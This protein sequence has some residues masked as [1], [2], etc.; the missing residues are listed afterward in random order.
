MREAGADYAPP[1]MH[2]GRATAQ[3]VVAGV[4]AGALL[5]AVGAPDWIGLVALVVF[6]VVG[7]RYVRSAIDRDVGG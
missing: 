3:V 2:A 1:A 7:W 6:A 5:G 4:L